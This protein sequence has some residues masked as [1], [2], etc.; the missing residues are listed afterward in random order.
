MAA[1]LALVVI[2]VNHFAVT[3][4]RTL[5]Q[6]RSLDLTAEDKLDGAFI[7]AMALGFLAFTLVY[8]W[9]LVHRVRLARI[10]DERDARALD[11]AI[12]ERRRE[13]VPA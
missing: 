9:L 11:A 3:W 5:H 8:A 6:G 4:W 10:E 1:L 13:A 12:E 7:G 2:P